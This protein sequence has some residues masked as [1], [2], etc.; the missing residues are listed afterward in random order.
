M[1]RPLDSSVNRGHLN[2][3]IDGQLVEGVDSACSVQASTPELAQRL[4]QQ[5]LSADHHIPSCGCRGNK[6]HPENRKWLDH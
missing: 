6:V 2:A 5:A 1:V 4:I 3:Y